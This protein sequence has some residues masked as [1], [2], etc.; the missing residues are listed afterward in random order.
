MD[1]IQEMKQLAVMG[2]LSEGA[3]LLKGSQSWLPLALH[4]LGRVSPVLPLMLGKIFQQLV[5]PHRQCPINDV[6][7]L[8]KDS[9]T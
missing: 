2:G 4:I 9:C 3:N 7:E 5:G 8:C 6:C 1:K